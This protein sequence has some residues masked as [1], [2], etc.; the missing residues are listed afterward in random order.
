MKEISDEENFQFNASEIDAIYDR[1]NQI[2]S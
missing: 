2:N 1:I